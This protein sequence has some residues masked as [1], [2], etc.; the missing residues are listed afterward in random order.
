MH[1]LELLQLLKDS[2]V[3]QDS[4]Y[5]DDGLPNEALCLDESYKGW[6]V[7]YSEKGE[8]TQEVVFVK[9]DEACRYFLKRIK[10]MLSI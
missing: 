3:P 10:G 1:K 5:L 6:S 8:R 4:F 9:E 2:N 7:Y